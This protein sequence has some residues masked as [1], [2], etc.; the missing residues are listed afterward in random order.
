MVEHKRIRRLAKLR[1]ALLTIR[2]DKLFAAKPPPVEAI[3]KLNRI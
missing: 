1:Q 3:P 2:I